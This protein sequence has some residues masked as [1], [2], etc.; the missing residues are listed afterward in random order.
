MTVDTVTSSGAR[1]RVH[2]GWDGGGYGTMDLLWR[3]IKSLS[4][5]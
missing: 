2:L 3:E 4:C 1:D 5:P